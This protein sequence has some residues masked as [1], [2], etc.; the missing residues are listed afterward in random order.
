MMTILLNIAKKRSWVIWLA[1]IVSLALMTLASMGRLFW[2]ALRVGP[3]PT[4]AEVHGQYR[5]TDAVLLDRHGEVL[6]RLRID[7]RGRRL[8]WTPL[9]AIS[10]AL[11]T[12]VVQAED[13]RFN[14]HGGV[15]CQ[16]LAAVALRGAQAGSW[17]GASIFTMQLASR[18]APQIE[19]RRHRRTL[20]QKF[21]QIRMAIELEKR[22]SK[23]EILEAY[24][25]LVTFR[26]ELQ[27][28]AAASLG[29]FGKQPHGLSP[30]ES[31]ILAA[32]LRSP[33]AR[34]KDIANRAVWLAR[35]LNWEIIPTTL[36]GL[37]NEST[38]GPYRM[39]PE[40]AWAPHLA[41]LFLRPSPAPREADLVVTCTLDGPLQ[42]FANETLR[43]HLLE[44]RSRHVNDGAVLVVDNSSGAVLAYVG[45]TGDLSDA[46]QVDGIQAQRQAGSILKPFLYGLAFELRLMTPASLLND[47][48]LEMGFPNGIYR[49]EN[50]DREFRGLV[51]VRTAL[52]SSLNI[53]AVKTL[54]LVGVELFVRELGLL[55]FRD[56]KAA[57]HYGP[58]L[59]LGAADVTLWDLVNAYRALAN[60]GLWCP[61][62]LIPHGTAIRKGWEAGD[63]NRMGDYLPLTEPGG[64]APRRVFSP[65]VAFLLGNILSDRESRSGTF[66]LESPLATRFWT[67]VKTGT[68][69]DMRDNWCIGYSR[70]YTVG[71]W[72]GNFS[73]EPMWNVLGITGAA[74]IWVE[75]MNWLPRNQSSRPPSPP[76]TLVS[77]KTDLPDLGHSREEWYLPGTESEVALAASVGVPARIISPTDGEVMAWDPDI[78]TDQQK[79]VLESR[80]RS[81]Q[82]RW[83]LDGAELSGAEAI[84]FWTPQPGMHSLRLLT[85]S[86]ETVD[87]VRFVVRGKVAAPSPHQ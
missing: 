12:A 78:P 21:Q 48:S 51:T 56:L 34:P 7:Q 47:S 39:P 81:N 53:P 85:A 35:S 3:V 33:N 19:P 25:N 8:T 62:R 67:A 57:D 45:S 9:E 5:R 28:I 87:T 70:H 54:N 60:G 65:E 50:Y 61:A 40:A 66:S 72:V 36:E 17:R 26:G 52:A 80:P 10:P 43:R 6:H 74:P 18:L 77:R 16:A 14:Q 22:W 41:R 68:S 24:L 13:R 44:V 59:A 76:E 86:G 31:L 1:A 73:G 69:K 23:A 75:I 11:V 46:P 2:K 38:R 30:P 49:P 20:E 29:L 42:R 15:D 37:V 64:S 79:V 83:E 55:G 84:Q 27:G 82:L 58:S 4:F 71:V 63:S 32:L